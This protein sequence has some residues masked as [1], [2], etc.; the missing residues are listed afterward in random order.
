MS[1]ERL[2]RLV[3]EDL[4]EQ[5][6]GS[7]RARHPQGK[8]QRKGLTEA[9]KIALALPSCTDVI[10]ATF[11]GEEQE[12]A[13]L[14]RIVEKHRED[15]EREKD[16]VRRIEQQKAQFARQ[17]LWRGRILL[18]LLVLVAIALFVTVRHLS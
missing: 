7:Y 9:L 6:A 3:A 4:P 18:L 5:M 2:G 13:R 8:A 16:R 11:L 15:E 14:L 17:R 10:D 1:G 12:K